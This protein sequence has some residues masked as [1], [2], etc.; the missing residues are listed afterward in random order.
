MKWQA[1]RTRPN[2]CSNNR[3]IGMANDLFWWLEKMYEAKAQTCFF[4]VHLDR[5][6]GC[7]EHDF[8]AS[9]FRFSISS[10][11]RAKWETKLYL[12]FLAMNWRRRLMMDPQGNLDTSKW[13]W[14]LK[15]APCW[16]QA[17]A[18]A[19]LLGRTS[20]SPTCKGQ[21]RFPYGRSPKQEP[22][23]HRSSMNNKK[24]PF[25]RKTDF[26]FILLSRLWLMPS[27]TFVD[28]CKIFQARYNTD[29]AYDFAKNQPIIFSTKSPTG[30]TI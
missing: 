2:N 11:T 27:T 19:A 20:L 13:W 16:D 25:G 24:I 5:C 28:D 6:E 18:A 4:S 23:P 30:R 12:F 22:Q 7:S 15:L 3:I 21:A 14:W 9:T 26:Y 10:E 17:T 8:N 1:K 29:C